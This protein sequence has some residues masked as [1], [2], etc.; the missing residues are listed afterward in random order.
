MLGGVVVVVGV[1]GVED[2]EWERKGFNNRSRHA[3]VSSGERRASATLPA[4][5]APGTSQF[6]SSDVSTLSLSVSHTHTIMPTHTLSHIHSQTLSRTHSH[7][8]TCTRTHTHTHTHSRTQGMPLEAW[9]SLWVS[10]PLIS[11]ISPQTPVTAGGGLHFFFFLSLSLPPPW[12][13]L[14]G[15]CNYLDSPFGMATDSNQSA[16]CHWYGLTTEGLAN[17][18]VSSETAHCLFCFY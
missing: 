3:A 12:F 15:S 6:L 9:L 8:H 1:V 10:F 13:I 11:S 16:E 2:W 7:T 14:D 5:S 18:A 17:F 4:S